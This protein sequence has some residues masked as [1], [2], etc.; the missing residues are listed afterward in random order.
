[1]WIYI[2]RLAAT[3][4]S[5]IKNTNESQQHAEGDDDSELKLHETEFWSIEQE[6]WVHFYPE[7]KK[8]LEDNGYTVIKTKVTPKQQEL[9]NKFSLPF[10]GAI[11]GT[12]LLKGKP[13]KFYD[14]SSSLA[15][16][17][18]RYT[19]DRIIIHYQQKWPYME[20]DHDA[21][22]L[23]WVSPFRSVLSLF[24]LPSSLCFLIAS[25]R[26]LPQPIHSFDF[27]FLSKKFI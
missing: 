25:V 27:L 10:L 7:T 18:R 17:P 2:Q 9:I 12:K 6:P 16:E 22:L 24:L 20:T 1:M 15:R 3:Y 19:N 8:S 14:R 4:D 23:D 21:E 5:S 13:D 26:I 11:K